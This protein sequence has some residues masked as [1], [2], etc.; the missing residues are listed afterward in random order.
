[1]NSFISKNQTNY[2]TI[3]FLAALVTFCSSTPN[4]DELIGKITEKEKIV[5]EATVKGLINYEVQEVGANL[6]TLY[7]VYVSKF[8]SDSLAAVYLY[9]WSVLEGDMFKDYQACVSLLQRFRRNFPNHDLAGKAL[10]M[11][12]YTYSEYL[13]DYT[14]AKIAYESF[15]EKFP[16]SELKESV[17]F[18]LK[19]LG[20]TPEE[21]LNI[22]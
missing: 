9:N 1:M 13:K 18:E 21:I 16:N 15:L 17:E 3:I 8:G 6:R 4:K 10:F 14:N 2:L 11:E 5:Q 12:A 19:N 22:N 20:K 7:R